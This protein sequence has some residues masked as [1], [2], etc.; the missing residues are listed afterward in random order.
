MIILTCQQ[1]ARLQTTVSVLQEMLEKQA[2]DM[3]ATPTYRMEGGLANGLPK[4]GV[5]S[6][7]DSE[8]NVEFVMLPNHFKTPPALDTPSS[9]STPPPVTPPPGAATPPTPQPRGGIISI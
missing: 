2:V 5:T 1:V 4:V 9:G 6:D 3:V 7:L 8:S